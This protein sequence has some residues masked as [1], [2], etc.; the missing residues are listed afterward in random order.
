MIEKLTHLI[1]LLKDMQSVILA[2]SGGV[3]S[4][5]L[6]KAMQLADIKTL[7]VTVVSEIMP[8]D[9][10]LSA[11]RM[12][13]YLGMNHRIIKTEML[14]D[15]E[16]ARNTPERCFFCK[17]KLFRKLIDIAV[18]EKYMF[19]LDGSIADD[20]MDYRPGRKAAIK[21]NIKSPLMELD[22]SKK[23]VREFSRQIG[24]STWN[25]PSSP[26]LSTR[27]PYGIRITQEVLK[28]VEA[29]EDFIRSFGF[30][31][32][33][34]RDHGSIARIEVGEDEI[35]FLLNPETR[36]TISERLKSLGYKFISLDLDGYITGSLNREFSL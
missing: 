13:E 14:S 31:E 9:D 4:T 21:Y 22:I 2:Y 25:K 6:L 1:N 35:G 18:S 3:D 26:C 28:R 24:L 8:H 15:E 16:F 12:T 29:S 11:K 19:V 34:V 30:S 20:T 36:K 7:A 17:D 23:E 33:R 32:V 5:F 27:V 10:L